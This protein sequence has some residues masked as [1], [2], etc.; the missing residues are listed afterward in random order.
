MMPCM[1]ISTILMAI[2]AFVLKGNSLPYYFLIF[3]IGLTFGGCYNVCGTVVSV[4]L[5]S[6][7]ELKD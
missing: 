3:F 6:Q 2:V 1:F 7:P 5:A 4:D